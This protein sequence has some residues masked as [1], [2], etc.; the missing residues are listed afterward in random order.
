MEQIIDGL[1]KLAP[2]MHSGLAEVRQ[3]DEVCI[4]H[5]SVRPE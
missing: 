1:G 2:I 3:R 5:T 4:W